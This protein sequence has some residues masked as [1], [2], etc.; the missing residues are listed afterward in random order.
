MYRHYNAIAYG[1]LG[2][3]IGLSGDAVIKKLTENKYEKYYQTVSNKKTLYGFFSLFGF[4]SG[5]YIGYNKQ[6][7]FKRQVLSSLLLNIL[8][9][10]I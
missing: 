9:H 6:L 7:G 3:F 4:C 10:K 5:V 2:Y 1:L 8:R